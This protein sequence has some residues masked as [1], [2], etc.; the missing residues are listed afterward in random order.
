[1][2]LDLSA[3]LLVTDRATVPALIQRMGRLNR[4]AKQKT[5]PTKPFIVIEPENNLPYSAADLEAAKVWFEKLAENPLGE[6]S[7]ASFAAG[8]S[9]FYVRTAEHLFKIE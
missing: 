2:S 8:S 6:R 3:D 1:M 5:D 4:R 9:A 7:L